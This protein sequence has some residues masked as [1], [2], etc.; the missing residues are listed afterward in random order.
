VHKQNDKVTCNSIAMAIV[1]AC[2]NYTI[3]PALCMHVQGLF[4]M[5]KT[6][7]LCHYHLSMYHT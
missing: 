3:V 6:D 5:T 2:N 4:T 1:H 7:N